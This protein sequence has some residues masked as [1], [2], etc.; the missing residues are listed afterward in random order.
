ML[1]EDLNTKPRVIVTYPGR[2]QPFHQGHKAVF[3]I[4]ARTFGSENVL[5]LTSDKTDGKK[6]PFNFQDKVILMTTSG[7]PAD[8][9]IE[10][11]NMYSL[12]EEFNAANTIFIAAVGSPDADR[13]RP[14]SVTTKD[15]TDKYGNFKPAG[16]PGYYK[17]WTGKNY[18]TADRHGYVVIIPEIHKSIEINGKTY[19]VSHG[20]ECR[21]LWNEI[22]KKPKERQE[23]LTQLYGTTNQLL[24]KI[25]DKIPYSTPSNEDLSPM[26]Q[27]TTSPISGNIEEEAAGVGVIANKKQR[28]DP[29]YSTSLTKDVKPGAIQH[30]LR[31][32]RLAET[33]KLTEFNPLIAA[34]A[35]AAG[36][37]AGAIGALSSQNP[38]QQ[39]SQQR[40]RDERRQ[41]IEKAIKDRAEQDTTTDQSNKV[42]NEKWTKKYKKSIN[43]SS[44][45]GFSQRAH[46][47]GRKARQQGKK[48]KSHSINESIDK[49]SFI[50]YLRSLLKITM[51]ELSLDHLPPIHLHKHI[52]AH[53][54]QATFGRF[55]NK[56]NVIH[57]AITGRHP[58]D[59][60][61]TLA[62]E[63]V[64]YKQGLDNDLDDNSGDTGSPEENE[65]HAIAGVILRH[66]NKKHPEAISSK[67]LL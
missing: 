54:G 52:S 63:L 61:R 49:G 45:K 38:T 51:T 12:P 20:T 21:N 59:I 65:A 13:L 58:V 46:C 31:G 27:S 53:E 34:G 36:L 64:H 67:P 22:R 30:A 39:T 9:I 41:A 7:V 43:C 3:D 18:V 35:A 60:F 37:A 42:V 57:L 16:S 10:T 11:S 48:T 5:V 8:K 44:P 24:E 47:A 40:I 33:K 19:D 29:R 32:F 14:D 1:L 66:F 28:K 25:F 62:H 2:F 4:L 23:Y 26:D 6:S 15:N 56:D 50:D 17:M 55:L